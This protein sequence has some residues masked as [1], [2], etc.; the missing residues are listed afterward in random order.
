[1]ANIRVYISKRRIAACLE[2]HTYNWEQEDP[3]DALS[4]A[5]PSGRSFQF[6]SAIGP[7][8]WEDCA[9][10]HQTPDARSNVPWHRH[11]GHLASLSA[12]RWDMAIIWQIIFVY[13]DINSVR[14]HWLSV[15]KSNRISITLTCSIV[16]KKTPATLSLVSCSWD[17]WTNIFQTYSRSP[18]M[19]RLSESTEPPA[20]FSTSSAARADSKPYSNVP[21]A[22]SCKWN[23]IRVKKY[24]AKVWIH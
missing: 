21:V 10:P 23:K 4:R 9:C 19:R 11:T 15:K 3:A 24:K 22:V 12:V 20:D 1:M 16:L 6:L 2:Q 7:W 5:F 13:A 17:P 8:N 18:T 14:T